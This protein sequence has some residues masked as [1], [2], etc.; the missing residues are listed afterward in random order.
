MAG[1]Y[2]PLRYL[3]GPEHLIYSF[4]D[5]PDLV[6]DMMDHLM[7]LQVFEFRSHLFADPFF[8]I[9]PINFGVVQYKMGIFLNQI[10]C[11]REVWTI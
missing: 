7:D 1:F 3:M 2:S 6:K 5:R 11:C 10:V 9:L 4:Y 8:K